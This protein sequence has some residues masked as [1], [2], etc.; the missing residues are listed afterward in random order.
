VWHDYEI[1]DEVS[2]SRRWAQNAQVVLSPASH[3]R[4][5]SRLAHLTGKDTAGVRE[6]EKGVRSSAGSPAGWEG[7]TQSGRSPVR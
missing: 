1:A 2:Q 7:A 6:S 5:I 4:I 3:A